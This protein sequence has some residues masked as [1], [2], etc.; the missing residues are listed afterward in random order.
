MRIDGLRS[1]VRITA[2]RLYRRPAR[3]RRNVAE[4]DCDAATVRVRNRSAQMTLPRS[5][6][7]LFG[8]G[9]V[10]GL[11]TLAVIALAGLIATAEAVPLKIAM[12][13]PGPITDN[14]WNSVGYNGLEAAAKALGVEVTFAENV[15]GADAERL[16]R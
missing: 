1:A 11:L 16:L 4:Q 14:D 5:L 15:S 7:R 9:R 10:L 2:Y 12:I 6:T 13:M 3:R 8:A